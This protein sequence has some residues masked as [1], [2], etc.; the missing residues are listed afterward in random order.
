MLTEV[1]LQTS[2]PM[3]FNIS[4][5][6]PNE[7]LILKSISGLTPQD[8]TIFSGDFS[9]D[10][11]YYQGRRVGQRFP[12][13][14]FKI[15]PNYALDIEVSDI[16]EM[17]YRAFYEPQP[18]TDGVQVLLKDDRKPD[19]FFVCYGEKWN[20]DIFT[21]DTSA[22][23]ST[24]CVDAYI[25]SVASTEGTNGLGWITVPIAYDG[26]ADTGIRLTIKV[27]ANTPAIHIEN[28]SQSMLLEGAFEANDIVEVSTVLGDRYIR[29]NGVDSAVLLQPPADW[30]Q[31]KAASNLFRVYGETVSDGKAVVTNYSFRS[32][33][34][35]V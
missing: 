9:R 34:R 25:Q 8:V 33:W 16:R 21:K 6:D 29:L 18:D 10:G 26:S 35:G 19:R 24:V 31:L 32:T 5:A 28:N 11:G 12:V 27:V 23:I 13:F 14:N 15:N 4:D 30:I 20:G 22:Q 17:L 3:S 1:V 2:S 7:I